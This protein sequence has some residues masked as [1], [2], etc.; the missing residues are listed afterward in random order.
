MSNANEILETVDIDEKQIDKWLVELD[1]AL[2]NGNYD[3]IDPVTR[4]KVTEI[5]EYA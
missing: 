3:I 1:D 5:K 2:E 4:E